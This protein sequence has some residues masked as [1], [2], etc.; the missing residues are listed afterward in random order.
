MRDDEQRIIDHLVY[1]V[2]VHHPEWK[3]DIQNAMKDCDTKLAKFQAG[4]EPAKKH[5]WKA[6]RETK[7]PYGKWV[8]DSAADSLIFKA[9]RG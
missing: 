7:D 8:V 1:H 6:I 9:M 2:V 5:I 4:R 3:T